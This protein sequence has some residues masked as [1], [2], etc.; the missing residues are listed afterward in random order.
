MTLAWICAGLIATAPA[1]D[2]VPATEPAATYQEAKA[3]LGR[4]PADQVELALWCEAHGLT[5][6]RLHHL[7]LAVLAD[8]AHAAARGLMGLVERDG[9]WRR[10]DAVADRLKADPDRAA[11]LA[12]YE[13]RRQK[14]GYTADAQYALG[15]WAEEHGLPRAGEGPPDGGGPARPV[16]RAGLEA[17]GL[18][19]A[20]RAM[21]RPTP[22]LLAEKVGSRGP[23]VGRSRRWKSAPRESTRRCST[24]P[25][26]ETR[27]RAALAQ[28]DRPPGGPD[29]R[30]GVR[31][32]RVDPAPGRCRCSAR[33][34]RR[35]RRRPWRSWPCSRS[36]PRLDGWPS[37]RC[38]AGTLASMPTS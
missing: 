29:D 34:T 37:R 28:R 36:R 6:E 35:P 19:E 18:Q 13:L 21:G 33:S 7:S 11:T 9:R 30:P 31:E 4:S 26:S 25:R 22:N 24:S 10:P 17:A 16:T 2:P 3:R 12:E 8:P 20:R 1:A 5:A 14:A 15:L 23:E 32:V 27:R 38:G